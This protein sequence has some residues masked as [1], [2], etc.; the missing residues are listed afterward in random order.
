MIEESLNVSDSLCR[1]LNPN[2][3]GSSM[4]KLRCS[5]RKLSS[6]PS[7]VALQI[8]Q[9]PLAMLPPGHQIYKT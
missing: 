5:W 7:F 1:I 2:S 9:R 8:S 4:K 3:P 6:S